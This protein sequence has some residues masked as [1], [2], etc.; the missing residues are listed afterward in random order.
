MG[1]VTY[2]AEAKQKQ[3]M[4]SSANIRAYVYNQRKTWGGG[5]VIEDA[6]DTT[7]KVIERELTHPPTRRT[8]LTDTQ[9]LSCYCY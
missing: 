6:L 5:E 3:N 2:T 7:G 8:P 9:L 4:L 1:T